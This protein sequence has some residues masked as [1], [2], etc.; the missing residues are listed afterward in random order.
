MGAMMVAYAVG[1]Q[2]VARNNH[3]AFSRAFRLGLENAELV[4]QLSRSQL[5]LQRGN[6]RL[7]ERVAVRTSQ[8]E[9]HAE[10]LR[11]AQRLEL[12][13]KVAGSLAHDFNNLLTVVLS[14]ATLL[15][16]PRT[17]SEQ[18]EAAV[19]SAPNRRFSV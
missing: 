16:D 13:G 3:R 14:T 1:M 9:Q 8:L 2:H 11:R 10:A 15:K 7:E 12:V 4:E 19:A 18:R 17:P 6:Q 5:E